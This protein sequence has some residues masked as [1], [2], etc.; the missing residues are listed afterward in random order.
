[1]TELEQTLLK[2]LALYEE[3]SHELETLI[4]TLKKTAEDDRN[5][6]IKLLNSLTN[7]QGKAVKR[8]NDLRGQ[9]TNLQGEFQRL[10]N[11]QKETNSLLTSLVNSNQLLL[12]ELKVG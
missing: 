10:E 2:E 12:E 5:H 4:V 9:V 6:S 11:V 8:E 1:M 7:E 3:R